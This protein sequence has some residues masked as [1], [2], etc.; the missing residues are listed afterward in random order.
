MSRKV[1]KTGQMGWSR[2]PDLVANIST[3]LGCLVCLGLFVWAVV[4]IR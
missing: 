4:L 2:E 3:A 1:R